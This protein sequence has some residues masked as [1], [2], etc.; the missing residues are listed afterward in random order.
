MP[1][2]AKSLADTLWPGKR[3][4]W[5]GPYRR[6]GVRL[7]RQ[8]VE[9]AT[10]L[11]PFREPPRGRVIARGPVGRFPDPD[12][13]IGV[14]ERKRLQQNAV[15]EAEHGRVSA[16]TERQTPMATTAKRRSRFNAARP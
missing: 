3:V 9:A 15:H 5:P 4:A 2:T 14:R 8:R 13:P 7:R 12:D 16:D 1:N 11:L 6:P 10:P